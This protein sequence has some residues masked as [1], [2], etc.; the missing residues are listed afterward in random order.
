ML[1]AAVVL[2]SAASCSGAD[3]PRVAD[4]CSLL[5]R[6]E[7]STAVQAAAQPGVLTSAIGESKKSLCSFQVSG[8]LGTVLVYLG[9]GTA[10]PNTDPYRATEVRADTYVIVFAQNVDKSFP[11]AASTLAQIAIHRASRS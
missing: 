3:V 4:A 6:E 9:D 5:T 8:K 7:V 1:G 2:M 11:K 10:P